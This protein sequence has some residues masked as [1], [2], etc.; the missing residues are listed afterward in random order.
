MN[1]VFPS[2]AFVLLFGLSHV[3]GITDVKAIFT[4]AIEEIRNDLAAGH[5]DLTADTASGLCFTQDDHV[6][7]S[8]SDH[9]ICSEL[10]WGA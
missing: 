5:P 1:T 2:I 8:A 6:Y 3:N 9:H 7:L 10:A 4:R